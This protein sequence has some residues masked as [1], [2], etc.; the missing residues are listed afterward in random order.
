MA[1]KIPHALTERPA[2]GEQFDVFL[3][4]APQDKDFAA[5]LIRELHAREP[6]MRIWLDTARKTADFQLTETAASALKQ[7]ACCLAIWSAPSRKGDWVRADCAHAQ[8]HGIPVLSIERGVEPIA[9]YGARLSAPLPKLEATLKRGWF[10]RAPSESSLDG[11]LGPLLAAIGDLTVSTD[12]DVP[13]M[14]AQGVR[15]LGLTQI[16]QDADADTDAAPE[17]ELALSLY[18]ADP[19]SAVSL[20]VSKGYDEGEIN[21]LVAPGEITLR[22]DDPHPQWGY[23][24]LRPDVRT[25]VPGDETVRRAAPVL[26][27]GLLAGAGLAGPLAFLTGNRQ[28][29]TPEPEPA[30]ADPIM[31]A[32]CPQIAPGETLLPECLVRTDTFARAGECT[33]LVADNG[34]LTCSDQPITVAVSTLAPSTEPAPIRSAVSDEP[35]ARPALSRASSICAPNVDGSCTLRIGDL[36]TAEQT[37]SHVATLHA[38]DGIK[39]CAVYAY[40]HAV[41]TAEGRGNSNDPNRVYASD[42]IVVPTQALWAEYAN[43]PQAAKDLAAC[44]ALFPM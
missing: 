23:W 8:N 5:A 21:T 27:L 32:D 17:D 19:A 18:D 16:L 15:P 25:P 10:S 13:A 33:D 39:T 38:G 6:A 41:F 1:N 37:L 3:S 36:P 43:T 35:A 42:M 40:N 14:R 4:Y 22:E 12:S 29:A 44:H 20:L 2:E 7:S 31:P 11:E 24:R 9:P 30:S 26:L 28:Q 34:A